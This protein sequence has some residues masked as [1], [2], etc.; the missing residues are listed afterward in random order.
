MG[1]PVSKELSKNSESE[2]DQEKKIKIQ[3]LNEKLQQEKIETE[4]KAKQAKIET[5]TKEMK[6]KIEILQIQLFN[7]LFLTGFVTLATDYLIRGTRFGRKC[8][9][10]L[11]LNLSPSRFINTLK[12]KESIIMNKAR[13]ADINS[14]ALMTLPTVIIGPTGCG[15][16]TLLNQIINHVKCTQKRYFFFPRLTA[17]VSLRNIDSVTQNSSSEK[18]KTANI[19][20]AA[21]NLFKSIGF[22]VNTSI[23]SRM[24]NSVKRITIITNTLG[25]EMNPDLAVTDRM[26]EALELLFECLSDAQGFVAL[27]EVHDLIRNDR[28]AESGG[29]VVFNY[30]AYLFVIH[31]VNSK[32]VQGVCAGSSNHLFRELNKT[33]A[34]GHR[35]CEVYITDFDKPEVLSYLENTRHIPADVATFIIDNCGTRLRSL[36]RCV[37]ISSL[38]RA[39]TVIAAHDI[40]ARHIVEEFYAFSETYPELLVTMKSIVDGKSMYLKDLP[41]DLQLVEYIGR[42]LY[43]GP[44]SQLYFQNTLIERAWKNLV[45]TSK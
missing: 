8:C 11:H 37:G 10:K 32:R 44:G 34:H 16:S 1:S 41:K 21:K 43:V 6:A 5:E 25:I 13:E 38:A 35:L 19:Q 9:V 42:V 7:S 23:S 40:G 39:Q 29:R 15:K 20:E 4:T 14:C 12:E 3:I 27:D 26:K 17:F 45:E 33:V 31:I 2:E 18:Q 36:E 24:I 30:L 22:P 28:L